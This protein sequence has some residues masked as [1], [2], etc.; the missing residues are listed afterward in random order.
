MFG[1]FKK[2]KSRGDG[3]EED[4]RQGKENA[5]WV[6]P[7]YGASR[8]IRLDPQVA[9]ENRCIAVLPGAPSLEAYK[10][11]R[12]KILNQTREKGWNTIMITSAL[13]AEG[14]TLTAINL[15]LTFAKEF[16][17]TVLLVDCDLRKQHIH[18]ML[19]I[20]SRLGLVDHLMK[21]VP[22]NEIVIWPG[23]E[24]FTLI[25]GG[26]TLQNS[27]ELLGSPKMKAIFLE[28]KNRYPDRYVFFDVPPLLSGSDAL[29]FSSLV[30]G[31]LMVVQAGKTSMED[32]ERA[33]EMIPREKF[34]GFVINRYNSDIRDYDAK[35]Y[36][37]PLK[38]AP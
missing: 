11:L 12:T 21:D 14:K 10:V 25:S 32:V 15:S 26:R 30:D 29:I 5:G 38:P 17:Q 23:I 8:P 27:A 16:S 35:T 6:N 34:L 33:V 36:G 1:R 37:Y 18:D 20:D 7:S 2:D 4:G 9:A 24:K 13:P 28:M 22:M 3:L 31:I 19:G